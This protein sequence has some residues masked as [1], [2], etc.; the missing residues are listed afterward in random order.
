MGKLHSQLALFGAIDDEVVRRNDPR[1]TAIVERF[2]PGTTGY[3]QR[4]WFAQLRKFV[5]DLSPSGQVEFPSRDDALRDLVRAERT[6]TEVARRAFIRQ[7]RPGVL[8]TLVESGADL[9][10]EVDT[11]N[12]LTPSTLARATYAAAV[13]AKIEG[14]RVAPIAPSRPR[15]VRWHD[16]NILHILDPSDP[17]EIDPLD[18]FLEMAIPPPATQ[19]RGIDVLPVSPAV[20]DMISDN[21]NLA[22]GRD[23]WEPFM[24]RVAD[25]RIAGYPPPCVGRLRTIDGQLCT[26]VSTE[27][28]TKRVHLEQVEAI[29]DPRNWKQTLPSFFCDMQPRTDDADGWSRILECVSTECREYTLRTALRYW[30]AERHED[31]IYINYDLADDRRGDSGLVEVDCGYIW[32]TRLRGGGVR[33]KTSK[34]LKICGLSPTAVAAL[35]CFSGWAQV[36]IDMLVNAA[37]DPHA[38]TVVFSTSR[39]SGA[40]SVDAARTPVS[41]SPDETRLPGL[42]PGF[43]QDLVED[44]AQQLDRYI[45]AMTRLTK[46]VLRR[47]QDGLSRTDVQ[48]LGERFGEEMTTLAVGSFDSVMGNFRPRPAES[49]ESAGSP[50]EVSDHPDVVDR[51]AGAA[52]RV[53]EQSRSVADTAA[54]KIDADA[55]SASDMVDTANRFAAIAIRG[56]LDLTT[57]ALGAEPGTGSAPS[58]TV[59]PSLPTQPK[60]AGQGTGAA[61]RSMAELVNRTF[62]NNLDIVSQLVDDRIPESASPVAEHMANVA[63]RMAD[64]AHTVIKDAATK[65]ETDGYSVDDYARTLTELGDVGL[66]NGIEITGTAL[67]G[68]GR[69]ETKPIVS[70][71]FLI[72][73][74][75]PSQRHLLSLAAPLTLAGRSDTT[76]PEDCV[77]FAPVDC[78]LPAGTSTFRIRIRTAGLRSGIYLGV[79]WAVPLD[80][81]DSPLTDEPVREQVVP[82]IIG[83]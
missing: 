39:S 77:T 55:Y 23:D 2:L 46:D 59:S 49:P 36:G 45:A 68:P 43:R 54:A 31:G 58:S 47:W 60:L 29:V 5:D 71:E 80:E 61:L 72:Q 18:E 56:W 32:I 63:R 74:A 25:P 33:I 70:D 66:I 22:R 9:A 8:H 10:P 7:I 16:G 57:I 52:R 69:H 13:L 65:V 51:V 17:V 75:D 20:R 82:L 35:A 42:P 14:P 67:I 1:T 40:D 27:V 76:I 64:Q 79:A 50:T 38:D 15:C 4:G 78:V 19:L 12:P 48:R 21:S 28:F 44:T 53:V 62:H 26:V 34:A 6:D 37:L 81:S 11:V 30:N 3:G 41:T 83:L 73:H 24:Q